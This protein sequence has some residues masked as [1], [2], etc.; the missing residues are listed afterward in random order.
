MVLLIMIEDFR[1]RPHLRLPDQVEVATATGIDGWESNAERD[2][3]TL[4]KMR[5][6]RYH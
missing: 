4:L 5:L 3:P 6:D 1:M 2:V